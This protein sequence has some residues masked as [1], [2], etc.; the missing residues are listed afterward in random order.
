MD[1]KKSI[2]PKPTFEVY[3]CIFFHF[4]TEYIH[5]QMKQ[6]IVAKLHVQE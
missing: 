4:Y 3:K 5:F 1:E 2:S 6:K